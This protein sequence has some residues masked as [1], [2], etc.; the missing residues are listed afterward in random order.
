MPEYPG[1]SHQVTQ[2]FQTLPRIPEYPGTPGSDQEIVFQAGSRACVI[3]P[4]TGTGRL[5]ITWTPCTHEKTFLILRLTTKS[6]FV[7][8]LFDQ[9]RRPAARDAGW[10]DSII[11]N[12]I[13]VVFASLYLVPRSRAGTKQILYQASIFVK[14]FLP[15]LV[16]TGWLKGRGPSSIPGYRAACGTNFEDPPGPTRMSLSNVL[17]MKKKLRS[18]STTRVVLVVVLLS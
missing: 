18:T 2:S 13:S 8:S 1:T 12:T 9:K 4:L 6:F 7:P 5:P 11:T 15:I 17:V 16:P 14:Q 3:R 10:C